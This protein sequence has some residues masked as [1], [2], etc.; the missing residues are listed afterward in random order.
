MTYG[1]NGRH[2]SV[3]AA[4]TAIPSCVIKAVNPWKSK[5]EKNVSFRSVCSDTITDFNFLD[6]FFI[7]IGKLCISG[8]WGLPC[9][10]PIRA[11]R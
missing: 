4:V 7:V 11:Y 3:C 5:E 9:V 6:S 10:F 2:E 8:A 1:E